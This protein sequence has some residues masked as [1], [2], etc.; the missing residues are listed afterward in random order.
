MKILHISP[1]SYGD[2]TSRLNDVLRLIARTTLFPRHESIPGSIVKL[3]EEHVKQYEQFV[4]PGFV[5]APD[6][7]LGGERRLREL[8]AR[9]ASEPGGEEFADRWS[10]KLGRFLQRVTDEAMQDA[11]VRDRI[12]PPLWP[13]PQLVNVVQQLIIDEPET[14]LANTPTADRQLWW[15]LAGSVEK[16]AWNALI[17]EVVD[18]S[19]AG[20]GPNPFISLVRLQAEGFYPLGLLGQHFIVFAISSSPSDE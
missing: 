17:W 11:V 1:G 4:D 12:G 2:A 18:G 19:G 5:A 8:Q 20:K 3:A 9:I 13:V 14:L 6:I 7:V 15:E 10:A 16:N